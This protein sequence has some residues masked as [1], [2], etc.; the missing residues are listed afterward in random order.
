MRSL[1][2][3]GDLLGSGVRQGLLLLPLA[4]GVHISFR[5]ARYPDL[6]PDGS[7]VI[8][9]TVTVLLLIAGCNPALALCG[10][11]LCGGLL[12]VVTALLSEYLRVDR[13]LS[14]IGTSLFSY[15]LALRLL[16]RG[17]LP[18]PTGVATIYSGPLTDITASGIVALVLMIIACALAISRLGLRLRAVGENEELARI[19]GAR[20]RMRLVLGLFG[21]NACVGLSGSMILEHQRFAD[22]G[23]GTGS[24]FVGLACLLLG[25]VMPRSN[26]LLAGLLWSAIGAIIYASL[27]A[28]AL[29]V[30]LYPGDLRA[31]TA[32]FVVGITLLA[33]GVSRDVPAPLF[34]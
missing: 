23:Q 27:I 21:A 1:E 15:S 24:L 19:L 22:V 28:G 16:G 8:G 31:I 33:R 30:G 20:T 10:G 26:R 14:G 17:N 18:L 6:T 9:S 2:I 7:I 4:V 13:I 11:A 29:R 32:L 5:F 12:G 25:G 34:R 3:L